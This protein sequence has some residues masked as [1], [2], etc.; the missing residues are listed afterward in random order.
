MSRKA[1][2]V[3]LEQGPQIL[4]GAHDVQRL[5]SRQVVVALRM[6]DHD[7][8]AGLNR[9]TDNVVVISLQIEAELHQEKPSGQSDVSSP[10][11]APHRGSIWGP[12]L[13]TQPK[14]GQVLSVATGQRKSVE[15][16]LVGS[17]LRPDGFIGLQVGQ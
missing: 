11:H 6:G 13:L 2:H 1:S 10:G 17:E 14:G 16:A 8:T 15:S 5:V 12:D 4:P 3:D 7:L 9:F